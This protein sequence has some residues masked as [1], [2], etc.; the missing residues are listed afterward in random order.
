MDIS[1]IDSLKQQMG[2]ID[3]LEGLVAPKAI[4]DFARYISDPEVSEEEK[5]NFFGIVSDMASYAG[6]TVGGIVAGYTRPFEFAD[7]L[8]S[9]SSPEFGG[10]MAVDRKQTEDVNSFVLG[11]SRYTSS[12]FNYLLGEETEYGNRLMGKPKESATSLGPV[13]NPPAAGYVGGNRFS[14]P[15]NHI[16]K[17]LA[18]VDKPPFRVDSF[19]SGIPEYDAFMNQQVSPLLERAAKNLLENEFFMRAPKTRQ[20]AEVNRIIEQTRKDVLNLLEGHRIGDDEDRLND[21]RRR[22]LLKDRS[23]RL[24]AKK[25]LGITAEDHKLSMFQIESLSNYMDLDLEGIKQY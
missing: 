1:L 23:A 19:T 14:P 6:G 16:N 7:R 2:P 24:R 17:L 10:G 5:S 4:L 15:S 11:V 25:A 18:L 20:M 9:E 22:F 3:A 12:I 13:M 8:I 21:L